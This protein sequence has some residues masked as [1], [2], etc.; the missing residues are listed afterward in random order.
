MYVAIITTCVGVILAL[1]VALIYTQYR[2]NNSD[3]MPTVK[4]YWRAPSIQASLYDD[5]THSD[6]GTGA[7]YGDGVEMETVSTHSTTSYVTPVK[8]TSGLPSSEVR[9]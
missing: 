3:D 1:V 9:I 5:S 7:L 2:N 6:S 8:V 4:G